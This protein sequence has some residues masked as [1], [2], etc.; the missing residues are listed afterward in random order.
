MIIA[1]C[2]PCFL[3]SLIDFIQ[4]PWPSMRACRGVVSAYHWHHGRGDTLTNGAFLA[5]FY[6][7]LFYAFQCNTFPLTSSSAC[8]RT[9]S[10][11]KA[12][13]RLGR[14]SGT[15][16]HQPT[17]LPYSPTPTAFIAST[18][19]SHRLLTPSCMRLCIFSIAS[20]AAV[21]RVTKGR[22]W[23]IGIAVLTSDKQ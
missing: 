2:L 15:P 8:T 13:E 18:G 3:F 10:C 14:N 19:P 20:L 23:C 21:S 11:F 1:F 5:T 22:D 6:C 7:V 17:W 4:S 9:L 12:C 16:H